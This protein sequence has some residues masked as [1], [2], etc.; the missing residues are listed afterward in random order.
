[1]DAGPAWPASTGTGPGG[2][3][4]VMRLGKLAASG[5]VAGPLPFTA[6]WVVSSLRH[7]GHPTAGVQ[8]S[9]LAAEDARDPRVMMAAIVVL[10]AYSIAWSATPPMRR[11]PRYAGCEVPFSM[12]RMRRVTAGSPR[13]VRSRRGTRAWRARLGGQGGAS[14]RWNWWF[15]RGDH[16]WARK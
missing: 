9:G 2:A 6:A 5:C 10:G 13:P 15:V 16:A 4:R 11:W 3:L 1:M 8:L 14:S 12:A 7:T